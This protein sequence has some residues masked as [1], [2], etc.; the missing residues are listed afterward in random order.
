MPVAPDEPFLS[1]LCLLD[2]D[3]EEEDLERDL[4]DF[5]RVSER[6]SVAASSSADI[7]RKLEP[8]RWSISERSDFDERR[9]TTVEE[10][11][12]SNSDDT[13]MKLNAI[14]CITAQPRR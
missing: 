12:C 3:D 13:M 11:T 14:R 9:A 10:R 1:S 5:G 8:L 7:H 6:S 4:E 2:D